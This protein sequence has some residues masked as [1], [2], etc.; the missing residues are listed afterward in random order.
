MCIARDNLFIIDLSGSSYDESQQVIKKSSPSK[1]EGL[2]VEMKL[3]L[4][5][6]VAGVSV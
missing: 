4:V 1:L 6:V 3:I 2:N 5:D